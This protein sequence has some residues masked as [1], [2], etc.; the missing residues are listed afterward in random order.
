MINLTKEYIGNLFLFHYISNDNSV[1]LGS[2]RSV[3][4]IAKENAMKNWPND[5]FWVKEEMMRARV[6]EGDTQLSTQDVWRMSRI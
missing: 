4:I 3:T 1:F 6:M 5:T 2:I